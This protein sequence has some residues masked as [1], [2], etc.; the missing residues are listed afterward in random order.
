MKKALLSCVCAIVFF[1]TSVTMVRAE[2]SRKITTMELPYKIDS[3]KTKFPTIFIQDL[4]EN[5]EVIIQQLS[6]TDDVRRALEDSLKGIVS[7]L[8]EVNDS[9]DKKKSD[10]RISEV[11]NKCFLRI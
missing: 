1:G 2:E 4:G 9:L 5:G 8:D 10:F 3:D 7:V 11:E 6:F